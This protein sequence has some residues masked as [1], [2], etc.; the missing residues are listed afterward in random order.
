[1]KINITALKRFIPVI[2][3]LFVLPLFV[4]SARADEVVFACGGSGS[5]VLPCSGS[6]NAVYNGLGALTSASD[7]ASPITVLNSQGP[8]LGVF[9]LLQFDT[10]AA[11]P[12]ISLSNGLETLSGNIV[13]ASGFQF[14]STDDIDLG[15]DWTNLP[16]DFAAFLGS[17]TGTGITTNVILS[18]NS[19]DSATTVSITP[20]PEPSSLLL[21]GS[22]LLSFGGL[23]RRRILRA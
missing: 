11:V 12:N 20:T 2:V 1:M 15:V 3:G 13:L 8:E 22:G 19:A 10:S 17:A 4:Q 16:A 7:L 23:L 21:L 14:G 18:V 9:F 5:P 6:I